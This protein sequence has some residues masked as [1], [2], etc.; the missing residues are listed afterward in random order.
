M[1][2][3]TASSLSKCTDTSTHWI[4]SIDE[5]QSAGASQRSSIASNA[6]WPAKYPA[7]FA[8]GQIRESVD[9]CDLTDIGASMLVA[10]WP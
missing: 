7:I 3:S 8:A 10:A 6:N 5:L 4:M 2:P 9:Q 1:Q